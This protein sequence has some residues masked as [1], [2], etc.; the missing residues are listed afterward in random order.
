MLDAGVRALDIR[1][2][3]VDDSFTLEHGI[4]ELPY[5]FDEDVRDVLA[6]FLADN[7]TE[8]VLMFYQISERDES[9]NTRTPEESLQESLDTLPDLWITGSTVPTLNDARGKVVLPNDMPSAEQNEYDLE[10]ESMGDKKSLI[11]EFF[12]ESAPQ[13]NLLRLNYFSGASL[14]LYPLTVAGGLRD[15]YRG[16]NEVV[17]EFADGCLGVTMFDFIGEDAVAHIV[18]QQVSEASE[19]APPGGVQY[20]GINYTLDMIARSLGEVFTP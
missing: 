9:T 2:R 16:T 13:A 19:A 11:R 14:F 10:F 8:T 6:S 7:P 15:F 4:I 12:L 17:F 18:A 1:L 3:H 20:I 5:T